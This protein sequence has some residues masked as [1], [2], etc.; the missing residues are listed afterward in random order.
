VHIDWSI[1]VWSMRYRCWSLFKVAVRSVESSNC[2]LGAGR[3]SN[4]FV[5]AVT[6][7][8]TRHSR[9]SIPEW[10]FYN[11]LF[12]R[13]WYTCLGYSLDDRGFESWQGQDIFIISKLSKPTLGRAQPHI[14]WV[15][16]FF[17]WIRREL[18]ER[19]IPSF[20]D[21]ALR[22]GVVGSRR[23]VRTGVIELRAGMFQIAEQT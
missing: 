22:H 9:L 17:L 23:F 11:V 6:V 7:L 8:L 15:P 5:A 19:M 16:G 1:Y 4:V 12:Q 14:Q 18:I 2:N 20:W 13:S 10:T 3:A 21:M